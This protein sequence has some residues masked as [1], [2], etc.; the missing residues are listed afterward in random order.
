MFQLKKARLPRYLCIADVRTRR[1]GVLINNVLL[2]RLASSAVLYVTEENPGKITAQ[3]AQ[4]QQQ[5]KCVHRKDCDFAKIFFRI[6]KRPRL[7]ESNW[8]NPFLRQPKDI[9]GRVERWRMILLRSED[10]TFLC[11]CVQSCI[12]F[13][14]LQFEVFGI[15]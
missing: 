6:S 9:N 2:S 10:S 15:I 13:F 11:Y 12:L 7:K 4:T 1:S 14:S 8:R 3:I 5:Q